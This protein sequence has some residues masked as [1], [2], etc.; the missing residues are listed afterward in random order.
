[1]TTELR[2]GYCALCISRCGCVGTLEDGILTR[3]DAE[4]LRW[5]DAPV[6]TPGLRWG[7]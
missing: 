3:V 6:K 2:H 5:W 1:M 7:A 4:L